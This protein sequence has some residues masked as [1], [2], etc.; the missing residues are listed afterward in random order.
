M[1]PA[2]EKNG[3]WGLIGWFL[4]SGSGV[5]VYL[6]KPP[7]ASL[8][9]DGNGRWGRLLSLNKRTA[10]RDGGGGVRVAATAIWRGLVGLLFR[11]Q[12]RSLH[13]TTVP[14]RAHG[15]SNANELS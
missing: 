9:I 4:G 1:H 13:S 7:L 2:V 11:L 10:Q 15:E 3:E 5:S 14:T 6:T 8:F 12:K